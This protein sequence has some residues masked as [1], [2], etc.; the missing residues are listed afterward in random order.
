MEL[1]KRIDSQAYY[2]INYATDEGKLIR[3]TPWYAK[4]TRP[5]IADY[6]MTYGWGRIDPE[7]FDIGFY[8]LATLEDMPKDALEHLT[9]LEYI[10]LKG[11]ENVKVI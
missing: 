11:Q 1:Y 6:W 10:Q 8:Q 7:F 3:N 9:N 4:G 5:L 2:L